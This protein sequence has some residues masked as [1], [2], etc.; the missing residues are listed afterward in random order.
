MSDCALRA[1][2]TRSTPPRGQQA[3]TDH[4]RFGSGRIRST[5]RPGGARPGKGAPPV[6]DDLAEGYSGRPSCCQESTEHTG[7][8]RHIRGASPPAMLRQALDPRGDAGIDAV[9][10]HARPTPT[11]LAHDAIA[12][13]G[14]HEVRNKATPTRPPLEG[15]PAHDEGSSRAMA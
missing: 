10:H 15:E 3:P 2:L 11:E 4:R 9:R 7:I 6:R 1:R 13:D 8:P 5:R 14:P 12:P